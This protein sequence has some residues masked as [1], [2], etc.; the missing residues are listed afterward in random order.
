MAIAALR[1]PAK[2][3]WTYRCVSWQAVSLHSTKPHSNVQPDEFDWKS[4]RV[5]IG[6]RK[7][8][9]GKKTLEQSNGSRKEVDCVSTIRH[10]AT[11]LEVPRTYQFFT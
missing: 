6:M 4:G 9:F 10:G 7:C 2:R 3:Y 5:G 1:K 8:Q 11:A